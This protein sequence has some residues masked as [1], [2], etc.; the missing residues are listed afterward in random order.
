MPQQ[1]TNHLFPNFKNVKLTF[2]QQET[3]F[4]AREKYE[5]KISEKTPDVPLGSIYLWLEFQ[6]FP[7][8]S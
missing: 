2:S 3:S 8:K 7:L 5:R 6:N 4:A 1:V